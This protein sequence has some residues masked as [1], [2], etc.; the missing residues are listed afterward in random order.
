MN[1]N[2]KKTNDEFI[3][4]AIAIHNDK[5]IYDKVNYVNNKSNIIITCKKHGD[6]SQT[7]KSHLKGGGCSKCAILYRS[8]KRQKGLSYYLNLF[9]NKHGNTYDYSKIT[10]I[11]RNTDIITVTCKK[12]GDFKTKVGRHV[13]YG[14]SICGH[15][16]TASIRSLG[17]DEFIQ[18]SSKKHSNR[19]DYSKSIYESINKKV[20]IICK[21]HGEFM[22]SPT[23]HMIG[24]GCPNCKNVSRGENEV[25]RVL[26]E[27]NYNFIQQ[28][29]FND[30]KHKHVL[31]FDFFL[32]EY[33]MCI[34][35]DGIQHFDT[36]NSRFYDPDLTIRDE[37]K[38]KYC[39]DNNIKLLRIP[40]NKLK[41]VE[42]IILENMPKNKLTQT[43]KNNLFI[44]NAR[45][46][47]GYKYNYTDVIYVDSITPI[48]IIYDDRKYRQ[49]PV[50]H[51]MGKAI[52]TACISMTTE[53][54][55]EKSKKVWGDDRFDYS[56]TKYIN[57]GTN[58]KMYD[59]LTKRHIEQSPKSH[60]KGF[61]VP[62]MS[63]DDYIN[64][65]NLLHNFKYDYSLISDTYTNIMSRINIKCNTHG[66]FELKAAS[67]SGGSSCPKCN[68]NV[69][70]KLISRF[71]KERNIN[72]IYDKKFKDC[73]YNG[74]EIPF[75]F[76]ISSYNM[77]IKIVTKYDNHEIV[78]ICNKLREKYC[79]DNYI[80][81][82]T[83]KEENL[84][85]KILYDCIKEHV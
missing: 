38:N 63:C 49:T 37:I 58:I 13:Y 20:I 70:K 66:I 60:L 9:N 36:K 76:Y 56:E 39:L 31:K 18:R 61:E 51:L 16:S 50:K 11:D 42:K 43:E 12:H 35:F 64:R 2:T 25:H 72:F 83:I 52:E 21:E 73:R 68:D 69:S 82:I 28:Y 8:I 84:N 24:A 44:D 17:I 77:I 48:T 75:D 74:Q 59:N 4:D 15:D 62:K 33:N 54:Y 40:Y 14:C 22:Q 81:Y 23:T 5:Y 19:Y 80:N 30:C 29:T 41:R 65:C 79:E 57:N 3:S 71:L 7:P 27:Y 67:H 53:E 45:K 47:W 85:E 10:H 55:V 46:K 1:V 6:F 78:S 26:Q 34:E 32:P